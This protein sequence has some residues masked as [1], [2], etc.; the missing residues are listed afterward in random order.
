M[1][2]DRNNNK[3]K[4]RVFF[5]MATAIATAIVAAFNFQA[6]IISTTIAAALKFF[7]TAVSFSATAYYPRF[8][9]FLVSSQAFSNVLCSSHI[10]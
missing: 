6:A 9:D 2:H 10:F 8:G 7:A 1:V 3:H 5:E 4:V